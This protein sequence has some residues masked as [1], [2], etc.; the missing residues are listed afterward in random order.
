MLGD[1]A[2]EA[3]RTGAASLERGLT[4]GAQSF[5]TDEAQWPVSQPIEKVEA[6]WQTAGEAEYVGDIPEKKG[7]L[8]GAFVL[9][10]I[11]NATVVSIDTTRAM[12]MAGVV[13]FVDANDVPGINSWKFNETVRENFQCRKP[14]FFCRLKRSS[15]L[16]S[17]STQ[18]SL[19]DWWW[20]TPGTRYLVCQV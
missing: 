8:H 17:A 14:G 1:S 20:H 19:W 12:A 16:G 3:V 7:E 10:N 18:D 5:D 11:A 4:S 15:A 13:S 9:S 6:K 2:S